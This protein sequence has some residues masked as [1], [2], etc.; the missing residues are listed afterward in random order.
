MRRLAIWVALVLGAVVFALP[1]YVMIAMSLKTAA[2]LAS[3]SVWAWPV[4][5]AWDNYQQ[6]LTNA[7]VSFATFLRN[8]TVIALL[9]TLGS[10][11]SSALVA[12]AFARLRF[13]GRDRLFLLVLA[14]MM[15]PGIV[16]LIPSYV[17][18]AQIRWVDT[19]LPLIVPAFFGGA[20]NIFLLRQ[21]FLSIPREMEEAAF[22][23]GASHWAIFS[24]IVLP[25]S[26]P[27]LATVGIFAFIW[28]WRDFLG[29]LLFLNDPEK[30]TLETGLR[31]YQSLNAEQWHLLM[32]AS[33]MVCIP[34]IIL[35]LVGQRAFIR[36]I[37]LTGGK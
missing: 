7:N 3:T 18:F 19:W 34:L 12:Y 33:V 21:F 16:T 35:F 36:G 4:N 23:D 27:A 17:M 1:F 31:L 10:V 14:T 2:E 28:S 11:L 25:L 9:T 26:M 13:P 37:V 32:A 15:L 6:V 5:P 20:Y 29:P 8:T 24:K 30:Q 22:L